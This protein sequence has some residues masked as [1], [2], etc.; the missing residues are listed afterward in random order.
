ML[1][2]GGGHCYVLYT[3][4]YDR[5]C[6]KQC[7]IVKEKAWALKRRYISTYILVLLLHTMTLGESLVVLLSLFVK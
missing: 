2:N 7:N 1:G 4:D 3:L 6:G 5:F